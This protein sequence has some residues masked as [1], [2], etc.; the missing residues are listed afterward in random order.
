[1]DSSFKFSI[2]MAIYNVENY[3]TAAIESVIQQDIGFQE[4]VQLIL[5]D[6]GSCD[7]S[8]E[9]CESFR[10]NIPAI[11]MLS[12]RKTVARLPPEILV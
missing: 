9:I 4:N 6:D 1:M 3:L 2:I 12:T 7:C 10:E 11:Y 8:G 5:V